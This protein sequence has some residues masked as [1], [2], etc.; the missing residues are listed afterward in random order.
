MKTIA[1]KQKKLNAINYYDN[2]YEFTEE[3][4]DYDYYNTFYGPGFRYTADVRNAK[5]EFIELLL[6][7]T[8]KDFVKKILV[9]ACG[10]GT[11]LKA[12]KEKG[13]YIVG[14]D[15]SDWATKN[16]IE[17]ANGVVRGDARL[18]PFKDESFDAIINPSMLEHIPEKFVDE[19]LDSFYRVSKKYVIALV[20]YE[21]MGAG[22]MENDYTHVTFKP[23][24]WW[25]EKFEK[26]FKILNKDAILYLPKTVP[27]SWGPWPVF[28]CEKK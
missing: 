25:I 27:R 23:L 17:K 20:G 6:S 19:V 22:V 1:E 7:Y 2:Y 28:M 15:I 3:A 24:N 11:F 9:V 26:K 5:H 14:T 4:Y 21:G 12:G 18:L 16:T 10:N 8:K 13:F